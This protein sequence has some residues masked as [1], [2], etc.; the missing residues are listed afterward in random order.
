M[1]PSEE[2]AIILAART[3]RIG[4]PIVVD[5]IRFAAR[6]DGHDLGHIGGKDIANVLRTICDPVSVQMPYDHNR[7]SWI[8]R[9]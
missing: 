2:E 6:T 5:D 8:R 7:V 1:T 3:F 4:A 9:S